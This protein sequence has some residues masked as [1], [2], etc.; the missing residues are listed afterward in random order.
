MREKTKGDWVYVDTTAGNE[1]HIQ[2]KKLKQKIKYTF[3]ICARN[4]AGVSPPLI[5]D[6]PIT[7]GDQISKRILLPTLRDN[8]F[9]NCKYNVS[10][11]CYISADIAAAKSVSN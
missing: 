9:N 4:E 10:Y 1:T 7:I 6:E 2:I 3:K 11:F 5:T 8:E